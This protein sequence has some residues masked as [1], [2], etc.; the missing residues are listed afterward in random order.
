MYA[1]C[2]SA[3]G[4]VMTCYA[5]LVP[6]ENINQCMPGFASHKIK[7]ADLKDYGTKI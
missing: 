3:I 2:F 5:A 7:F 4:I 6:E 1:K